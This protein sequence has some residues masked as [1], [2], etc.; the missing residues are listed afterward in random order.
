MTALLPCSGLHGTLFCEDWASGRIRA[1]VWRHEV[2]ATGGGNG[3]FQM[4]TQHPQNSFVRDGALHIRPSFT[5]HT[6]GDLRGDLD[7]HAM[8]CTSEWNSGCLNAGTLH[9]E[10]HAPMARLAAAMAMA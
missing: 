1:D 8:G 10:P 6:F 3:E 2:G 7:L 4:Y 5:H 9:A